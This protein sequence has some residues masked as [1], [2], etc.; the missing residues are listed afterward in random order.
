MDLIDCVCEKDKA[1][2]YHQLTCLVCYPRCKGHP[3]GVPRL[4]T[5][6]RIDKDVD[7]AFTYLFGVTEVK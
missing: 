5:I 4:K 1:C 7:R 3:K 6:I 2:E